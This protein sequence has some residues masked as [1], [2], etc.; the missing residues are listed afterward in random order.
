MICMGFAGTGWSPSLH[1]PAL[2]LVPVVFP[3]GGFSNIA[4]A[5]YVC[6]D[7]FGKCTDEKI[8]HDELFQ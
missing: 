1:G 8:N 6:P 3:P 5:G 7:Y 4:V 2:L